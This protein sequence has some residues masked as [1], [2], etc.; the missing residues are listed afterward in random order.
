M[1][2]VKLPSGCKRSRYGVVSTK[3]RA[4]EAAT[5][6]ARRAAFYAE[7]ERVYGGGSDGETLLKAAADRRE[8]ARRAVDP[9]RLDA[10]K[11]RNKAERREV[12]AAE[13]CKRQVERGGTM[14]ER[15]AKGAKA[16][17]QKRHVDA[18]RDLE[19]LFQRAAGGDVIRGIDF[20]MLRVDGGGGWREPEKFIGIGDA[21]RK[22]MSVRAY[23]GFV[24]FDVLRR[25][26]AEGQTMTQVAVEY[27]TSDKARANGGCS[28]ETRAHVSR[29]V[30]EG[31]DG[32]AKVLDELRMRRKAA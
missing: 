14:L 24:H 31:L 2:K 27:E 32:A 16:T 1:G 17:L 7:I 18:G 6:E 8:V 15:L 19:A 21:E 13:A 3:V 29:L 9:M 11:P 20:A 25:M 28:G 26:L 23:I 5:R 10:G 12:R 22:L 30:R 4:A